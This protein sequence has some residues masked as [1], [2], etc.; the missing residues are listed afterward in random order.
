MLLPATD[1]HPRPLATA[2]IDWPGYRHALART[3]YALLL[4]LVML[5]PA[6]FVAYALCTTIYHGGALSGARFA[7]VHHLAGYWMGTDAEHAPVGAL[8]WWAAAVWECLFWISCA[9]AVVIFVLWLVRLLVD[10]LHSRVFF[11]PRRG[12]RPARAA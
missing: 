7:A 3:L 1:A 9:S 12:A 2:R 4:A 8:M 11:V 6:N 10:R 5:L